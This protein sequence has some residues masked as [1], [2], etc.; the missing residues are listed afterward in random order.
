MKSRLSA[1]AIAA[2]IS[3]CAVHQSAPEPIA[4]SLGR[5]HFDY[6]LQDRDRAHVSQVFDDGQQTF[7]AVRGSSDKR[8]LI[9]ASEHGA[10]LPYSRS[11]MYVVIAG[12]HPRLFI[13]SP[14]GT[15]I[16]A[17][18]GQAGPTGPA[19]TPS[20]APQA[21]ASQPVDPE[22]LAARGA[23][24]LAR[25]EIADLR[26][27]LAQARAAQA[28]GPEAAAIQGR[29]ARLEALS[30]EADAVIVRVEFGR[31]S[32]DF[33]PSDAV[34]ET[35]VKA[36]KE[37]SHVTLRSYT[38]ARVSDE[39]NKRIA[40]ARA[41]T[42]RRFLINAGVPAKKIRAFYQ[43]AGGFIA[44]NSTPDGRAKNRR[45]EIQIA[46]DSSK[47]ALLEGDPQ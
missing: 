37:A 36:A 7:I 46:R 27:Q 11:G 34:A 15:T 40:L 16:A 10:A 22:I 44:D 18:N 33:Q 29:I 14:Q 24:Q 47:L 42:A 1:A 4:A 21:T 38:D 19:A 35:L 2:A 26:V 43:S 41:L 12:V 9:A 45:V 23:L 30:G 39:S 31:G 3:G 32:I 13:T 8:L 6:T 17:N 28:P 20:P 25:Q 5:Y